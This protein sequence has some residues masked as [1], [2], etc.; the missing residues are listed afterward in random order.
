MTGSI[1]P[2]PRSQLRGKVDLPPSKS[3]TNRGL[4]A[5]AVAGGGT[6]ASPLD[7][8]DTRILAT[9]LAG[10]GWPVAW[11]DDIEIGLRRIPEERVLLDLA[12]S[13]T[14]VRL[15][16]GLLASSPGM[17]TV[18]G[19]PRLRERP[20]TPLLETLGELGADLRSAAGALPIEVEGRILD[21]GS[22]VV[23]PQ[24]SS[25]FVSSLVLAAPLMRR[26]LDLEV[27]GPLPSAP[28]LDLT[29]DVMRAFGAGIEVSADRRLWKVAPTPLRPT[30]FAVEGDWSAAAF[31]LA[32][33]AIAGG[34]VEVG[35]LSQSSRQGDR[36]VVDILQKSGLE[37]QS[38]DDRLLVRGPIRLPLSAD[39]SDTPDLFPALVVVAAAAPGGSVLT[40]LEHLKHKESDR[41]SVMVDNLRRLGAGLSVEETRLV[42]ETPMHRDFSVPPAVTAAGDHR[43][44]MAM[45]VAALAA[46]PLDL[47]DPSCVGKSFPGFWAMWDTLTNT[48]QG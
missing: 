11:R 47:D 6:V 24:V 29:E 27:A 4:I 48:G 23:R 17:S 13:G 37:V 28:Y 1:L 14:G 39:L 46:G 34:S 21:G 31:V 42:V 45:A 36:A 30:R 22:A 20:M 7:C 2:G 15:I 19:N 26:G 25:Q 18:D 38:V 32:A 16:L 10:A 35:P 40:G 43:I 33:A 5:A 3:L 44:A 9:A 12:E 41:L 8:D